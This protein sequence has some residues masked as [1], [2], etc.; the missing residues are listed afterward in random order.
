MFKEDKLILQ[1]WKNRKLI[2]MLDGQS[3]RGTNTKR[4]THRVKF[5]DEVLRIR[6]EGGIVR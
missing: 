5:K 4:S 3:M 6:V 1:S 2:C